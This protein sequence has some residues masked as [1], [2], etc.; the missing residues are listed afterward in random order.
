MNTVPGFDTVVWV[1]WKESSVIEW[2]HQREPQQGVW[3]LLFCSHWMFCVLGVIVWTRGRFVQS[4]GKGKKRR[5]YKVTEMTREDTRRLKRL[6]N[7][8]KMTHARESVM[9]RGQKETEKTQQAHTYYVGDFIYWTR[10]FFFLIQLNEDRPKWIHFETV[11]ILL[12]KTKAI[13]KKL[14]LIEIKLK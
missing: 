4:N 5:H 8:W 3:N 11:L 10:F 12:F 9:E 14:Y 2:C 7:E 13:K 1:I 6:Q